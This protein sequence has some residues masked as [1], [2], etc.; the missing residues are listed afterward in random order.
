VPTVFHCGP[1]RLFFYS[2]DRDEPRHVHVQ[3]EDRLAKFWLEPVRLARSGGFGR[4]EIMD[5]QRIVADNQDKLMEAWHE[6]FGQ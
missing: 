5:I 1:Y 3:R 2:S 6:Y 4:Q